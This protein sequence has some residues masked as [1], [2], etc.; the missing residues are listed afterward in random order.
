[1]RARRDSTLGSRG[2]E[3]SAA[4]SR[5]ES[6]GAAQERARRRAMAAPR[7]AR[8]P[9][10]SRM[11]GARGRRSVSSRAVA[12]LEVCVDSIEALLRAQRGGAD[13]IELCSRLD[14]GGLSPLPELL[15]EARACAT[16]PLHVMV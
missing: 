2:D 9:A 8:E 10:G 5:P 14:L 15:D 16:V 6:S 11:R 12:L 7:R 13:R 1:M 3:R 4:R